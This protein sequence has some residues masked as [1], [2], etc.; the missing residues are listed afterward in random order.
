MLKES[1][2]IETDMRT[3]DNRNDF[4]VSIFMWSHAEDAILAN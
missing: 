4:N 2:F 1:L 3:S